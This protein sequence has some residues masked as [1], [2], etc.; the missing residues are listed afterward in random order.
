MQSRRSRPTIPLRKADMKKLR[1]LARL[2]D[3]MNKCHA[4][5]KRLELE[6]SEME[7]AERMKGYNV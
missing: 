4:E 7:Y 2:H 3:T 5:A 1:K 6:L